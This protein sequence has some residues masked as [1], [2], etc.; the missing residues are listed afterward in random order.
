MPRLQL[1]A[2]WA[3]SEHSL[4]TVILV[5]AG[6]TL[7]ESLPSRP[8]REA[9]PPLDTTFFE[10]CRLTRPPGHGAVSSYM[11]EIYGFDPFEGSARMEEVFNYIYSDAFSG[12]P[13]PQCLSAHWSLIRI[14][15]EVIARTTN[16][17]RGVSR[18]GVGSLL[19]FLWR[20]D[21]NRQLAFVTFNQDLLIEKSI[22]A[23]VST[24]RYS[25]IPW[26]FPECYAVTFDSQVVY[27]GPSKPFL[28]TG[29]FSVPVLKLHGSLNWVYAVRSGADPKNSIRTPTGQLLCLNDQQVPLGRVTYRRP[30]QNARTTDI[31]SLIVPPIYEKASRY[32]QVLRPAW[33]RARSEIESADELVVFGYSFPDADYSTTS[34]LLVCAKDARGDPPTSCS[35]RAQARCRARV[36][37]R[38]GAV[39]RCRYCRRAHSRKLVVAS[40]EPRDLRAHT[41]GSRPRRR[42]RVSSRQRQS[43]IRSPSPLASARSRGEALS[44]EA[45]RPGP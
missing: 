5:G 29:L 28:S 26:S 8:A 44:Y 18:A 6:A 23:A 24:Q 16:P 7:A 32:Q 21:P 20:D 11:R 3:A 35:V 34:S 39:T 4:K 13:T 19:R 2:R 45:S 31:L 1:S 15:R 42:P 41:E 40:T 10:L 27:T 17:L 25:S 12:T 14:Y 30:Q 9:R 43:H 22:A 38:S 37:G 36:G 33:D